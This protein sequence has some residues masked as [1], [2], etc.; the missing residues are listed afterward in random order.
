LRRDV[1]DGRLAVSFILESHSA[2]EPRVFIRYDSYLPPFL[3]TPD[4]S[5]VTCYVWYM[6]P[7]TMI[8][9]RTLMGPR[10]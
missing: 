7:P 1:Q 5:A 3:L 4:G 6:D 8:S 9:R 10:Q 2:M